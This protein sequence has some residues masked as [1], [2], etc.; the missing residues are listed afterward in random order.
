MLRIHCGS[1]NE[2]CD[3]S[4]KKWV[5]DTE[6]GTGLPVEREGVAYARTTDPELYRTGRN[7]GR[8]DVPVP[9]GSYT[10]ALHFTEND[11]RIYSPRL[12]LFDIYVNGQRIPDV[13]VFAETGG[14]YRVLRKSIRVDAP[15]GK[16]RIS[17]TANIYPITLCALEVLEQAEDP[18]RPAVVAPERLSAVAGDM[19][20]LLHWQRVPGADS[21]TIRRADGNGRMP[22]V[23]RAV[24]D[25]QWVD[26]GLSN[27]CT[28]TYTVAAAFEDEESVQSAPVQVSPH[29]TRLQAY[30]NLSRTT[31]LALGT[32]QKVDLVLIPPGQFVMGSPAI[33]PGRHL[34]ERQHLV[35]ITRP[36]YYGK[37][38]VTQVQWETVMGSNPSHPIN[39]GPSKPVDSITYWDALEFCRRVS[40]ASGRVVRLPT[41]AEFE[42]ACRA[43]STTAFF[44]GDDIGQLSRYGWYQQGRRIS[45]DV[46][47]LWPNPLGLYD[48][49]G[50]VWEWVSDWYVADY[51]NADGESVDPI[52]PARTELHNIRGGCSYNGF[53]WERSACRHSLPLDYTDNAIGMRVVV[54]P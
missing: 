36:F 37:T 15:K 27:G 18:P 8:Y 40:A 35:T 10:V 11:T 22:V 26:F 54:E 45:R 9:P 30:Q 51:E 6:F 33:E 50:N 5:A 16:I 28:Y 41:E 17:Q 13:D 24:A 38:H 19:C 44:F 3:S 7:I 32:G 52:G 2:Y 49:H 23:A 34:D 31:E 39:R 14:W 48:V 47:L 53:E 42:Y 25:S 12:R 4:G 43:G 21:Y 29:P 1:K 46:G 20:A